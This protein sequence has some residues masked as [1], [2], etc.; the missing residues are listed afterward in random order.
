M[1][2]DNVY[3]VGGAV[4]DTLLG[5]PVHDKDFVVVGS[6]AAE[7]QSLGFQ[8]VGKDF[9]VFLHPQTKDEY[10]LARTE[11]KSG[12]GYRGFTVL[13]NRDVTLEQDLGRRD[14]TINAMAQ[15]SDGQ[16][17]DP[18]G[19]KSDLQNG[20]LRHVNANAFVEDPVRILRLARF[21]ARYDTFSV[22]D[23]TL[24]LARHMVANAEIAH[25]VS[26]RVW[27][28]L[29]RGLMERAPDRMFDVLKSTGA[30]KVLLPELDALWGVPA[31]PIK[32]HP[33]GDCG[34]HVMMVLQQAARI[35]APL[36]VRFAAVFHDLGKGITPKEFWPSHNGH[37]KNGL[38]LV[39]AICHRLKVPAECRHLAMM[40]CEYHTHVHHCDT[41]KKSTLVNLMYQSDAFRRPDR[42]E[43][44]LMC[45]ECDARGRLGMQ[46]R[47]YPQRAYMSESLKLAR[48]VNV[49]AIA[50]TCLNKE[51]PSTSEIPVRIREERIR[52]MKSLPRFVAV[53]VN[54]EAPK[55]NKI[56][57]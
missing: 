16:I 33:E 28:E 11:R 26:E 50:A 46:D 47:Q 38:P 13:A 23:E 54:S 29:S 56:K 18:Y 42:F 15:G 5:L 2:L 8:P 17:I 51:L 44:F 30:L 19:G 27:Q 7:M 40:M 35:N 10:A 48:N 52:Q 31:G 55:A 22:A 21:A 34:V 37:E 39:E 24:E 9:P 41:L 12:H 32:H 4:R 36:D 49:G 3:L 43:R 57:P 6:T 45:C 1:T 53:E 25:L 20:V 14:L